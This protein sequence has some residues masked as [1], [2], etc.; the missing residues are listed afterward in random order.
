MATKL[1]APPMVVSTGVVGTAAGSAFVELGDARVLCAVRGPSQAAAAAGPDGRL[2][3]T[4][5]QA[6]FADP[7]VAASD[8]DAF[9]AGAFDEITDAVTRALEAAALLHRFPQQQFDVAVDVLSRDGSEAAACIVAAS[10]A[11]ADAGVELRDTLGAATACLTAA[12]AV[13]VDATP[14]DAAGAT[15]SVLVA[16]G[17]AS[18]DVFLLRHRGTASP[19]T[20]WGLTQAALATVAA[21]RAVLEAALAPPDAAPVA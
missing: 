18:G 17:A 15:A 20:L 16:A 10:V 13:V 8:P 12:G 7:D 6:P 3:V 21:R 5:S 4:L 2:V 19:D 14:E 9:R 1:V 11:L